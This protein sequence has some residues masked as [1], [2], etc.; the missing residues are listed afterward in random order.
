MKFDIRISAGDRNLID[1][2][3]FHLQEKGITFLL[4]ES[5]IGKS[6]IARAIYG[7]L[8]NEDLSVSINN[9]PYE[10]YLQ[11]GF[12]QEI[13]KNGF[14]VFQEPSSHL[15]PLM[16]LSDQLNEGDLDI[17]D[18]SLSV[19][20]SLWP[21]RNTHQIEE[22]IKVYPQPYRPSGGEKQRILLAMAL[23]KMSRVSSETKSGFFIFDEPTGSLDNKNR[24]I[25]LDLLL[26]QM[27]QISGTILFISHDYSMISRMNQ[28]SQD[29]KQNISF[30]ELSR[31]RNGH[32]INEFSGKLYI[33]W[34][35]GLKSHDSKNKI[36]PLLTIES[37][38]EIF[39]HRYSFSTDPAFIKE[40]ALQIFPH[41][42][43]YLKAGS[44][45][46]KT[47]LAKILVG[48]YKAVKLNIKVAD[49]RINETTPPRIWKRDIWARKIGMIFQHADEAL[50]LNAKV[51][52]VF[53]GLPRIKRPDTRQLLIELRHFFD[54]TIPDD[55]L[56]Q[57]IRHLSG[58]QKQRLN[59]MR[60]FFLDTD[61]LILDEPLNGLD[62]KS[63]VK[64]I[65]IILQKR[66]EEK[67]I[68]L[69]S[70]NEEIFDKL[71][72]EGRRYYL[73]AEKAIGDRR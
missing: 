72:P 19:L 63:M 43:V 45:V 73:R 47:T 21:E 12:C 46:G 3:D 49:L 41:D 10:I 69:I 2:R 35:N 14:F 59:I 40:E 62:F 15:N 54:D 16:K 53:A 32:V 44:G 33:N 68:L 1:I 34:L 20:K 51:K 56:E 5:G 4:G 60:T 27:S 25:F 24:D 64:I 38:F 67:G 39:K 28:Y 13:Q 66:K 55:F 18:G 23:K 65:E 9:Q 6:L 42:L 31:E 50:N 17:P 37:G 30:M 48:L 52:D 7:L 26:E 11:N 61:I 22:L 71:V 8:D 70:H 36:T 29:L 57:K 58:G